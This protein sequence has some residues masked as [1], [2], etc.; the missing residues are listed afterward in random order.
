MKIGWVGFHVEGIPALRGVLEQ[1]YQVEAMVTLKPEQAA[2]RSGVADYSGLCREFDVPLIE[3]KNIN[4]DEAV[5][6]LKDLSL[7][8]C[9]VIGW[10]QIVRREALQ[11]ARIGMVGAHASLLPHNRGRAPINWALIKGFKETGNSLIWL[12]EN[13]DEGDLIAQTKFDVTP[14]D[15]CATLYE[16]VASSNRQMILDVLPKLLAGER[17]GQTQKHTNEPLLPGRK[18]EDGLIDW[19][20]S[21]HEIY[22][23]VRAL[24]R[25]YPGA[26]STLDGK[27]WIVRE[28]A[29]IPGIRYFDL[30]KGRVIGAMQS[31]NEQACG[32]VV[33]C[34]NDQQSLGAVALLELEDENGLVLK[35]QKLSDQRWEGKVWSY[36]Q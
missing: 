36:E 2:K 25:P 10:S 24:A 12:A 9:F 22:D 8:V 13:V 11:T 3:I 16:K 29:L 33:A 4:D 19:S 14:Y 18:P 21:S 27:R 28:C 1:G 6:I 23:F 5:K 30:K 7:D 32:Q 15:T 31:P 20:K 34:G 17:P 26:F 35:G